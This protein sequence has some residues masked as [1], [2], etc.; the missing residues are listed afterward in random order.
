ML[1]LLLITTFAI[2]WL[3]T[4][5]SIVCMV[6][7]WFVERCPIVLNKHVGHEHERTLRGRESADIVELTAAVLVRA[8][9]TLH[10]DEA[11]RVVP[12]KLFDECYRVLLPLVDFFLVDIERFAV[13]LGFPPFVEFFGVAGDKASIET[14]L[15]RN[16]GANS[17]DDIAHRHRAKRSLECPTVAAHLRR[18]THFIGELGTE[19]EGGLAVDYPF[20][21]VCLFKGEVDFAAEV[22][23]NLY[24]KTMIKTLCIKQLKSKREL[25]KWSIRCLQRHHWLVFVVHE[26]ATKGL[27]RVRGRAMIV[28]RLRLF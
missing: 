5:F 11:A 26:I 13:E 22:N 20:S 15:S 10:R 4:S 7:C 27:N 18:S 12:Q 3:S 14:L 19:L 23:R 16:A 6:L 25:D 24:Y 17:V 28:G 1:V 9:F 21:L 2:V 8:P